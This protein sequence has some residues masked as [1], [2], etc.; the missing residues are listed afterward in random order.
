MNN[1]LIEPIFSPPTNC[2]ECNAL[3]VEEGEYIQCPNTMECPAQKTGR[4]KNW[5][6]EL[7]LLEWG[8]TLIQKLIDSGKVETVADLYLLSIDDLASLERMGK[9]SAKK[10]YDILWASKEISLEVFLG[11]LS[12][13]MIGQSTIKAI[14]ETGVENLD[15]FFAMTAADFEKVN[16]V[17][18]TKAQFLADGLRNNKQLITDILT[19]GVKIKEKVMGNLTGKSFCFTGKAENKR[20][21]LEK[22]VVD[23]GGEV[24]SSVVKGL[25]F[26]VLADPNSTSS[27]AQKA[28]SLGTTLISE[29]DFIEMAS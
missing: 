2:P 3:L 4:I 25:S 15:Q 16:G 8:E 11:G 19:N 22:L 24:K 18:P 14:M 17:G 20:D 23:A 27:K 9:K 13:K 26:L 10:A 6:N 12:I 7:N 29:Q 28:R 1:V 21:V 5:I